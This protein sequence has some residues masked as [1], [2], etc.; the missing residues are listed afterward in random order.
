MHGSL[1]NGGD[2]LT[3]YLM[4]PIG[5]LLHIHPDVDVWD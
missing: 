1:W 3:E 2:D 4:L 5:L